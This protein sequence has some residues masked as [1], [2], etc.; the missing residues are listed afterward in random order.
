MARTLTLTPQY[1]SSHYPKSII[2]LL[3]VAQ[4]KNLYKEDII[5]LVEILAIWTGIR[6]IP[7]VPELITHDGM[8][9]VHEH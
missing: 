1:F 6:S 9:R 3:F 4:I 5:F 7:L 8:V 2:I